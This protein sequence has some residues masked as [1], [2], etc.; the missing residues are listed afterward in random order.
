MFFEFWLGFYGINL[1]TNFFIFLGLV[2]L[3][4]I[5][6]GKYIFFKII[7]RFGDIRVKKTKIKLEQLE[8]NL[9]LTSFPN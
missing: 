2:L 5:Y 3:F 8:K 7:Y 4:E 1:H 9:F 6:L